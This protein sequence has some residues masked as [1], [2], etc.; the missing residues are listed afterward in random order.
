MHRAH[1]LQMNKANA[2]MPRPDLL[3]AKAWSQ[4]FVLE[5]LSR[6]RTVLEDPMPVSSCSHHGWQ[7]G[8]ISWKWEIVPDNLLLLLTIKLKYCKWISISW[9]V[10]VI[11]HPAHQVRFIETS[12]GIE[13]CSYSGFLWL[14]TAYVD[15][16]LHQD[17][18][19]LLQSCHRQL[20]CSVAQWLG[21]W[22]R[23]R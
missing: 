13:F 1:S 5:L 21:R 9:R 10:V 19:D 18:C 3:E 2:S 8:R 6:S 16:L 14:F 11:Y 4:F 22:I 7:T 12:S 20:C 15:I 23:D 17:Q